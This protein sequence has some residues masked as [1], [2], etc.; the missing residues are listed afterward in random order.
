[1]GSTSELTDIDELAS[2]SYIYRAYGK[3]VAST[4]NT[5]NPFLWVGRVG[6][7]EDAELGQYYVRARH[8]EPG[9][10]RWLSEDPLG[11]KG[12]INL[13][14]YANSKPIMHTDPNGKM[15]IGS[16]SSAI[17]RPI[18]GHGGTIIYRGECGISNRSAT[19]SVISTAIIE[20]CDCYDNA[21]YLLGNYTAAIEHYF[22]ESVMAGQHLL[23]ASNRTVVSAMLTKVQNACKKSTVPIYCDCYCSKGTDAYV[24]FVVGTN[25][26][27]GSSIHVCPS[28]MPP[29]TT[30]SRRKAIMMHEMGR[31]YNSLGEEGTGTW[32]DV[33]VWDDILSGLCDSYSYITTNYAMDWGAPDA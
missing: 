14:R 6:Y 22:A 27:T 10:A 29:G 31:Y 1:M 30:R 32:A 25:I 23:I 16:S 11:F 20:A 4:G 17:Y 15:V 7:Y 18:T 24:N 26:V 2:D 33:K 12:G 19:R 21:Q 5:V 28:F 9:L 8:Y 3:L 13:Y